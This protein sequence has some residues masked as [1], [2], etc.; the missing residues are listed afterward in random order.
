MD[1]TEEPELAIPMSCVVKD[2]L[3]MIYFRRDPK[4]P[5]EVIRIDADLGV[6]D[7]RWVVVQS[8]VKEGDEV[9]LEGAYEL[10]LA[11]SGMKKKPEST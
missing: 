4:Y 7:G 11:S 8:G 2:G 6:S 3:K 9:V 10:M 1:D 5:N